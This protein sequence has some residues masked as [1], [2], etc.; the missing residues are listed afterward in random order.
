M[1]RGWVQ[2]AARRFT[3]SSV[4]PS[5]ERPVTSTWRI[6]PSCSAL[7]VATTSSTYQAM[8]WKCWPKRDR[9]RPIGDCSAPGTSAS[10][11]GSMTMSAMT[12]SDALRTA[13]FS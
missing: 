8:E 4:I 10:W 11:T 6:P 12:S 9:K 3:C 5:T 2:T 13:A 7:D 1:S